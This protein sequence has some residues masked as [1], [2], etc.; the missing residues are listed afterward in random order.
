MLCEST[1]SEHD[2]DSNSEFLLRLG[3]A[4]LLLR[5]KTEPQERRHKWGTE[6]VWPHDDEVHRERS[7]LPLAACDHLERPLLAERRQQEPEGRAGKAWS[8]FKGQMTSPDVL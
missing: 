4:L 6:G 2:E 3:A 8:Y 7:G 5:G 1:G